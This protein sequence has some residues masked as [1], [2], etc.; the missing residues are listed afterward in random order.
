MQSSSLPRTDDSVATGTREPPVTPIFSRTSGSFQ[1]NT[2]MLSNTCKQDEQRNLIRDTS[3]RQGFYTVDRWNWTQSRSVVGV[4]IRNGVVFD[5]SESCIEYMATSFWHHKIYVNGQWSV[6]SDI[7]RR[8]WTS[9][10][11]LSSF[12]VIV[13]GCEYTRLGTIQGNSKC[14]FPWSPGWFDFV[15]EKR[16]NE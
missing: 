13:Y 12:T 14:I 10:Y 15:R 7:E 1:K 6:A 4:V 2:R 16:S 8:R 3:N 5:M 11:V 9:Y